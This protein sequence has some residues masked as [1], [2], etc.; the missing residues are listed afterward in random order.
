MILA[1]YWTTFTGPSSEAQDTYRITFSW[2]KKII[3]FFDIEKEVT[4]ETSDIAT[5]NWRQLTDLKSSGWREYERYTKSVWRN[6]Y[7]LCGGL[8]VQSLHSRSVCNNQNGWPSLLIMLRCR[9]RSFHPAEANHSRGSLV[10]ALPAIAS[11]SG[12]WRGGG[13]WA[14]SCSS[15][16]PGWQTFNRRIAGRSL[17]SPVLQYSLRSYFQRLNLESV[18]IF[19]S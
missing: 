13:S 12:L 8:D 5:C 6:R 11:D 16:A 19:E 9:S 4:L 3:N 7:C 10:P 18:F 1:Y 15:R 17:G 14:S 2:R